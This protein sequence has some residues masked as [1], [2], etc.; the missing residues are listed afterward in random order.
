MNIWMDPI[1]GPRYAIIWRYLLGMFYD[2][3][4]I[5]KWTEA[6]ERDL[7]CHPHQTTKYLDRESNGL[8]KGD[9]NT[10]SSKNPSISFVNTQFMEIF[11]LTAG[12]AIHN[13]LVCHLVQRDQENHMHYG[14]LI[15]P[16]FGRGQILR[17]PLVV[18]LQNTKCHHNGMKLQCEER[19]TNQFVFRWAI[20]ENIWYCWHM[21][22]FL[23]YRF[24]MFILRELTHTETS[25]T[26]ESWNSDSSSPETMDNL[27][28]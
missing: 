24:N 6:T 1:I 10:V 5:C 22:P 18:W 27:S 13:F 21:L 3:A 20:L 28:D 4:W 7:H 9:K 17:F 26:S 23:Q 25:L 2:D 16:G 14:A 8:L 15:E 11:P 19:I 12:K